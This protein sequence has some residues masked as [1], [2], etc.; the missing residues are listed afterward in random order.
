MGKQR[1]LSGVQPTGNLHLGNYFGAIR[2]WVEIQSQY[3]N[4]YCVVDLHAITVPHN[5]ATLAADTYAIAALYLAC[6]ID[7]QYSTIFVQ[8]HVSAHS[9]LAWLLNCI[10][11]LNWLEDMIQFKEKKIKQ[12]ENV[13]MGLLDY[14]VLMA[15]DILLYQA[16]K[17]PVG[18]D[19]KQHLE[20]TRDL[21]DRFNYQFGKGQ[22][23]IKSPEPMIRKDGARV[24]SLTDGTR[25]MSKSDP[26]EL[27]RINILDSAEE[28]TK[29]IKRC[30]TDAVAGLTF[31]DSE[32]P[33]CHNLLTMY[34]LLSG[35]T[36]EEVTNECTDL[37]WGD[38][39]KLLTETTINSLAP[40]Q[41][42]YGEVM[43]EK[44]YLDSILREGR[45]K[46]AEIAN[47]TLNQVKVAMGY[48]LPM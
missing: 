45:Q 8:S 24:M 22:K 23:L 3:D 47:Q 28:I 4:Y 41:S 38:F 48:S 29:K 25:K 2:N 14:P 43:A 34:M 17:V 5:P 42:K 21:A 31:D 44:G 36:K 33:E 37:R 46:A 15:A 32:R 39:K 30:K 11:P 20:L 12:G 26:S 40:I 16:D 6:G 27:S 35:K 1:I 9:E 18:E 19:Q 13:G 7:L 10:T